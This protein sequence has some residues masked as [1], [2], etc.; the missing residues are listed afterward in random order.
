M[1]T[2]TNIVNRI[3]EISYDGVL[4]EFFYN[5]SNKTFYIEFEYVD[6]ED[7]SV[8][9]FKTLKELNTFLDGLELGL[10]ERF[11]LRDVIYNKDTVH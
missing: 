1:N 11:R 8:Y 10:N 3:A 5:E 4:L 2:Y 6:A 7:N 9:S